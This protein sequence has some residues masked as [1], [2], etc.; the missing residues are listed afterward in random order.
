MLCVMQTVGTTE[1][2]CQWEAALSVLKGR[3]SNNVVCVAGQ[4]CDTVPG[5]LA[6]APQAA[7]F[8]GAGLSS[9]GSSEKQPCVPTVLVTCV[10]S[11]RREWVSFFSCLKPV[12]I[13]SFCLFQEL[14]RDFSKQGQCLL[15]ILGGDGYPHYLVF[16]PIVSFGSEKVAC[17][18]C[19]LLYE[20]S[21]R[22]RIRV[23]VYT[24][25][26]MC[27]LCS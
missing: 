2:T 23:S 11:G 8:S 6:W 12:L 5:E 9:A 7:R 17:A 16:P 27:T 3:R 13:F 10:G 26:H 21:Q 20:C 25:T 18:P 4:V 19:P 24:Q 1:I 22:A 15:K 14:E